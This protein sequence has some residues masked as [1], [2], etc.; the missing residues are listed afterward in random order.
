MRF[1]SKYARA[2]GIALA[3]CALAGCAAEDVGDLEPAPP[4]GSH[5]TLAFPDPGTLEL[6]PGEMR[7]VSVD[8][9]PPARY[10]VRFALLGDALDASLDQSTVIADA[11]GRATVRLHAP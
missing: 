8:A 3:V 1:L 4:S 6:A 2:G 5:A 9:A 10:E 7:L 11:S